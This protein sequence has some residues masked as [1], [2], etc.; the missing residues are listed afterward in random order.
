MNFCLVELKMTSTFET[1]YFAFKL[2]IIEA[3]GT[4]GKIEE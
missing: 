2:M 4:G 1:G 3:M